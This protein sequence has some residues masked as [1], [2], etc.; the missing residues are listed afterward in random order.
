VKI[1][2]KADVDRGVVISTF[3]RNGW[4]H[5]DGDDW[6]VG[7]FNVATVRAM[8]LPETRFRFGDQQMVNH[9]PNHWE[10]TR[11][12]TMVKNIKRFMRD[13]KEATEA[14]AAATGAGDYTYKDGYIPMTYNLPSDYSLFAEE[15][16][17]CGGGTWIMKPFNAAQGRGIFL[18]SPFATA[19]RAL[20]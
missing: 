12:D 17:R 16:K 6:N 3:K 13:A 4:E 14:E 9:Y 7:W 18:V 19:K 8:F 5:T 1:K 11:K 20:A 2:Y 10:L 15:Y